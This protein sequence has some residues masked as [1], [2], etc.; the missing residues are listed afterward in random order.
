MSRKR[1]PF[2]IITRIFGRL[3]SRLIKNTKRQIICLLL[4]IFP[5]QQ[6]QH[7]ANAG[8]ILPTIAMIS[9]VVV[10][11]TTAIML[12][13]F[14]RAKNASNV[15]V[16]QAVLTAAIPGIDRG[17]AKINQLF[18][19]NSLPRVT[20]TDQSLYNVFQTKLESYTFGDE[21]PLQI[22]VDIDNDNIVDAP[23]DTTKIYDYETSITAWRF[24]VDTD[25]NGK[26]DSYTLYG[27][28]FRTPQV[29]TN[30][31]YARARN[32]LEA[33]TTP[34][35]DGTLDANCASNTST[36]LVGST[37]WIKQ[38]GE[39]KK[40]FFVYT[41]TVPITSNLP[42][43]TNYE[44]YNSN[45]GFGAVEYEQ[46]RIQ[47]PSNNAVVYEDD[48][49]ITP[50]TAF[51]LN[52]AIFTNSNL[53]TGTIDGNI[54]IFQVSS[55][56][57]CFYKASNA[58]IVVG[59]NINNGSFT[60]SLSKASKIDLF[61]GTPPTSPS[62]SSWSN[63][64]W[65]K[66]VTED[67]TLTAYNNLAYSRR[68]NALVNAQIAAD[69]TGANDPTEVKTGVT[70]KSKDLGIV[71]TSGTA[72]FAKY[73][74]QQLERYFR[75][76][77]RKVPFSEV[78]FGTT[79]TYPSSVLQGSGDTLRA[80]DAWIYPVDPSDGRTGISYTKLT[81]NTSGSSLIP[82][83]S[84]PD[85][86]KA[87]SGTQSDLGDRVLIGHNLPEL[88]WDPNKTTT[89]K[90]VGPAI[91]DVQNISQ[92]TWKSSTK[93]R[94]RRSYVQTLQDIGDTSRDG[95]WELDAAK[96]PKEITDPVG[97]LRV[98][99]GAGIYLNDTGTPSSFNNTITQIWPDSY[100]I[101]QAGVQAPSTG[102]LTKYNA[103]NKTV[104][105]YW[106]YDPSITYKWREIP[107]SNTPYLQMR[108][109]AVYHYK[110]TGYNAQT[111]VPIACVS[112]FYVPTN[113]NTAQNQNTFA[114]KTLPGGVSTG[115]SNNG[116][117]FP[118]PTKTVSDYL[119]VLNYQKTLTYPNG[120]LID[121]GL[122]AR[123][124]AK[125]AANRTISEQSAIDAQICALQI[126]YDPTF[127]P[128][129]NSPVIDHGAI[130]ETAFLDAREV[131]QNSISGTSTTYN[132]PVK[133]RQPLEIR[134]TVLDINS[135]RMK[136]IGS[137]TPSQEYLLPNSGI[138]Y[139]TRDDGL[140]DMSADTDAGNSSPTEANKL[141]S[142]VD[143]V[144]DPKRR[145]NGIMLINGSSLGRNNS[146]VYRDQEK[147]LILASNLPVYI[148]GNFN[149][150]T[151]EEFTET[152][153]TDWSNFY[154]R[155]TL[156]PN[157]ACRTNDPRLPTCTTGD[158]WRP[159][160]VL[161]DAIALLSGNFR[162][163]FRN[164][165]DYDWNNSLVG[166][167]LSISTQSNI[168][169]S[170][171]NFFGANA[172]WA[173]TDVNKPNFGF[174]KN[175]NTTTA[176]Q[177]SSYVNN[178]VTPLI[179]MIP[180][181]QYAYEICSS[182]KYDDCFCGLSDSLD[183]C[184]AKTRNWSLTNSDYNGTKGQNNWRDGINASINTIKTGFIGNEP[185]KNDP[186]KPDYKPDWGNLP[187]KRIAV[188]R[189]TT[190]TLPIT[191]VTFYGVDSNNKV[192]EFPV[193]ETT[194][195]NIASPAVLMP[196]L[197]PNSSNVLEPVLQIQKPFAT[198]TDPNN[199]TP[200]N[201]KGTSGED[202]RR[203]LQPALATTTF[204]LIAATG[205]SPARPTEDNG[206]LQNFVRLLENWQ[207][208]T[209]DT[210]SPFTIKISG[211][212][213]QLRK[214]VYATGTFTPT[215]STNQYAISNN[216]GKTAASLPG[217][218]SW[219]YDVG[220]PSQSP[221]QFTSKL[222]LTSPDIANEYFSEVGRDNAWVNRLLCAR[223]TASGTPYAIGADQRPS[224]CQS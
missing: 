180:A 135:L 25:N 156:N 111:P 16:N 55:Q 43:T 162:E 3:I 32:P 145:P 172:S 199:T 47:I 19:D 2:K 18:A 214:S 113:S 140:P 125:T 54:R 193:G 34:M 85:T 14:E 189:D 195:P 36:Q 187:Y 134:A 107:N 1:H 146:N 171:Y 8:F 160:T 13:S 159:A 73:R 208:T 188:K 152:L 21:T 6:Q 139:A 104:A 115:L 174:P 76:R 204:N 202:T 97:G 91:A 66:S 109:T 93:T 185:N 29:G 59:G 178:F 65:S 10:L 100:P 201:T 7:T 44:I 95:P 136:T 94:T 12:R 60:G 224:T 130:R 64:D 209:A 50:D 98:V 186:T 120:R 153:N 24:P 116:I 126:R 221:D 181:R 133:D 138:I 184:A 127:V 197:L 83:A 177:G 27:I 211:A 103:A 90:F 53:L 105:P 220:L 192:S 48:L 161:A 148:K 223:T 82:Q 69:S 99:T 167:A 217:L 219:G 212:F 149:V 129:T 84:D 154:E 81:L 20:P 190:T 213:M 207:A 205:D 179:R 151:Q 157:F 206:G 15:R 218:R 70:Q 5:S 142:P 41:T 222:A 112:S 216:S 17:R 128:V 132:M 78:A 210:G 72:D 196:W 164:E 42:D 101:P 33:R 194:Q 166:T 173:E 62:T 57:S 51:N 22:W 77:T 175:F 67:S 68:I 35:S 131:Q 203:W 114:G 26:F 86:I 63:L 4:A 191:P 123:A 31:R 141:V 143:Y 150:H 75:R 52:G 58:F 182:D 37:G 137:S 183:I 46:D 38:N 121:D 102:S 155:A 215:S 79:E 168:L 45:K 163:G 61:N 39:L 11:M 118:P 71:L 92:V 89:N 30:D 176:Y 9:V 23:T 169:L 200:I 49:Q 74:R 106:L 56:K 40:S 96:V 198:Q 88:W 28:Y 147:G 108:A 144:L 170:N 110:S 124:L 165:G 122:L 119:A 158:T 117:V 87:N 80:N